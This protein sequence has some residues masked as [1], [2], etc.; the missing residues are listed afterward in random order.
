MVL[1]S[2]NFSTNQFA[3]LRCHFQGEESKTSQ[4]VQ[5]RRVHPIMGV[6]IFFGG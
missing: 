3:V 4:E 2:G 6:L 5:S 1:S